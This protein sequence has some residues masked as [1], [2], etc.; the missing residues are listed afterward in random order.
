MKQIYKDMLMLS[1]QYRL[2]S[3]VFAL[4]TMGVVSFVVYQVFSDVSAITVTICSATE[5][6]KSERP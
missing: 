2:P 5:Y 6:Q 3:L 4:W 1:K